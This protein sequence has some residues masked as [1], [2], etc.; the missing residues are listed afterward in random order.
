VA[1]SRASSR[2]PARDVHDDCR[3]LMSEPVALISFMTA[4]SI[5]LLGGW[6]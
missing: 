3:T 6:C 5:V 2:Q 4:F 1:T